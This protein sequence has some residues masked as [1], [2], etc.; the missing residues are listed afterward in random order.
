MNFVHKN[1]KNQKYLSFSKVLNKSNF[2]SNLNFFLM[3]LYIL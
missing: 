1:S 2:S 3:I